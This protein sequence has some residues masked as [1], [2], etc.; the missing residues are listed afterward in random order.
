MNVCL[1]HEASCDD[2]GRWFWTRQ[3][4][5][6]AYLCNECKAERHRERENLRYSERHCKAHKW[7]NGRTV[8]VIYDP[9]RDYGFTGAMFTQVDHEA[10]IEQGC[11]TVGTRLLVDGM[12]NIVR[13]VNGYAILV[14]EGECEIMTK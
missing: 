1:F 5:G 2:C 8:Q 6:H 13:V 14:A 10:N 4:G 9:D 12:E 3:N 11:Y 7:E